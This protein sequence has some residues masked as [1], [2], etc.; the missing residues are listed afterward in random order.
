MGWTK[1]PVIALLLLII[2]ALIANAVYV[3]RAQARLDAALAP[4]V[5]SGAPM[6]M[7]ALRRATPPD[8]QNA[9]LAMRRIHGEITALYATIEAEFGEDWRYDT[10]AELTAEELS[11]LNVLFT[12]H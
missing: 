10:R 4:A 12:E 1:W 2:S 8:D 3:R 11:K 7:A 9:A 6:T 5:A